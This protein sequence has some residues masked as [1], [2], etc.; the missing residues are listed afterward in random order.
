[1]TFTAMLCLV[2]MTCAA[3]ELSNEMKSPLFMIGIVTDVHHADKPD[4]NGRHYRSSSGKLEEAVRE[5]NKEGVDLV[6]SLGDLI[7]NEISSFK[8]LESVIEKLE[9]PFISLLG[10]HDY[11]APYSEDIQDS[12]LRHMRIDKAYHSISIKGY[13]LLF[14]DGT[15]MAEYSHPEGSTER[16]EATETISRLKKEGYKNCRNYNGGIGQRQMR[17]MHREFKKATRKKEKAVCFCHMPVYPI[18]SKYTLWNGNELAELMAAYPCVKAY[19]AGHHH[20][21][22]NG[23]HLNIEHLTL[24][25]MIEGETNSFAIL[26]FFD[27]RIEVKGYG[28]ENDHIIIL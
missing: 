1:M 20:S 2:A 21:G 4:A 6:I 14:L 23:K 27:D 24:K 9:M 12:V 13:R 11:L 28:R 10:N 7:D 19:I 8:T 25:G 26:S 18:M 5:F 16:D 22:G 17:W 15:D 3:S